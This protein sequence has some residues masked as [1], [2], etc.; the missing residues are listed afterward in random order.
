VSATAILELR[1]KLT[2]G[3]KKACNRTN[4]SNIS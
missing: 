3:P 1:R 2:I 4:S